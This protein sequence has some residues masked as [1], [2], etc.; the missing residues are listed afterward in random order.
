M[1][2]FVL[3][4]IGESGEVF[5][6]EGKEWQRKT[7]RYTLRAGRSGIGRIHSFRVDY[8]DPTKGIGG[9]FDV[10]TLESKIVSDH[11]GIYWGIASVI[12]LAASGFWGW[13]LFVQSKKNRRNIQAVEPTLEDRYVSSLAELEKTIKTQKPGRNEVFEAGKL[14]RSYL[15]ERYSV[16]GGLATSREMIEKI[17]SQIPPEELK[18]LKRIFDR[19]DEWSY[20]DHRQSIDEGNR[21]Y[22]EMIRY[23]E[24]K[25]I[26]AA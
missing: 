24:G 18:T 14:F 9:H 23:V 15:S 6:K 8:V 16:P 22:Q 21:L 2:G 7:F 19:L 12:L 5:Q 13:G 26:I 25:K 10:R 3:E 1:E 20:S 17:E 4:A 11:S